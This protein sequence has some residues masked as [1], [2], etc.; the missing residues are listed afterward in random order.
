M[1]R[2]SYLF[3]LAVSLAASSAQ[4]TAI[5]LVMVGAAWVNAD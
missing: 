3:T 5:N 2:A 1:R 4:L